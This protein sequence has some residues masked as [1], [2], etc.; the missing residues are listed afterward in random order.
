M[1]RRVVELSVVSVILNQKATYE[2]V[3]NTNMISCINTH[4]VCRSSVRHR[5]DAAFVDVAGAHDQYVFLIMVNQYKKRT[6]LLIRESCNSASC[7]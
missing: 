4:Y 5:A 3:K 1:W 2:L 6:S 7:R